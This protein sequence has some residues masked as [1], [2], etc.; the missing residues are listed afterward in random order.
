LLGWSWRDSGFSTSPVQCCLA[1]N[2]QP[3]V[4]ISNI[5]DVTVMEEVTASPPPAANVRYDDR[6]ADAKE[7]EAALANNVKRPGARM[8]LQTII[9]KLNKECEKLQLCEELVECERKALELK[10]LIRMKKDEYER[11]LSMRGNGNDQLSLTLIESMTGDDL[12]S[13]AVNGERGSRNDKLNSG[14][15]N[16]NNVRRRGSRG[17]SY[18]RRLSRRAKQRSMKGE[19][20]EE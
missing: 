13:L 9:T 19:A 15:Y 18:E 12:S 4:D 5:S 3:M 2:T 16:I 14:Q 10:N 11:D 17:P 6:L 7:L 20:E 8:H 1:I